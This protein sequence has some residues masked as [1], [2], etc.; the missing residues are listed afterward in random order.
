MTA[1]HVGWD[2][3]DQAILDQLRTVH[4]RLDPPPTDLDDRV[5]FA[6]ALDTVD[7][8]VAHLQDDLVVGSG[9]R[10]LD[11]M[12]GS[13]NVDR[14]R[15]LTFD[16]DSR[17]VMVSIVDLPDGRVRLDGWLAPPGPRRVELR[18]SGTKPVRA[19]TAD[20]SG[21]FVF[22]RVRRGLAQLRVRPGAGGRDVVT[23]AFKL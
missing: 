8:E 5:R 20:E 18:L 1:P 22:D 19:T 6:I 4:M 23:P 11:G 3:V 10:R 7:A 12:G 9:A 21:R 16:A 14:A 13:D 15:T 17:T 2:E